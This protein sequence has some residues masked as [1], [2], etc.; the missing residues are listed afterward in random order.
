MNDRIKKLLVSTPLRTRIK[1][2]TQMAFINLLSELGYRQGMWREREDP[3]LN[4]LCELAEKHTDDLLETIE[5]W[6][7]DGSPV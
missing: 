4:R 5:R 6:E 1:V 3:I 7:K 2:E